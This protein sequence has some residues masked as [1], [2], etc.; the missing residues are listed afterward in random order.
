[1]GKKKNDRTAD[2]ALEPV[3]DMNF[4]DK[5]WPEDLR[6]ILK[7]GVDSEVL[8][9]LQQQVRRLR[10]LDGREDRRTSPNWPPAWREAVG[11]AFAKL[12]VAN[13]VMTRQA[14]AQALM[15]AIPD[16]EITPSEGTQYIP[17]TAEELED[18]PY[19]MAPPPLADLTV[20]ISYSSPR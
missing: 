10:S 13:Q 14:G 18:R 9:E 5:S 7:I 16:P 2:I 1:M 12:A 15:L 3:P 8:G 6:S 11:A 19:L 20:A 4:A 17:V